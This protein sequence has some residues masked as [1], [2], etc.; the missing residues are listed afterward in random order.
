MA[1]TA[2]SSTTSTPAT[3]TTSSSSSNSTD[4]AK[5]AAAQIISSLGMG[6][7]V[8]TQALAQ[9]LADAE[10]SP[11]KALVNDKI[12]KAQ[13][14]ISGYA[15][16]KYVLGNLQSAFTALKDKSSFNSLT[17]SISQPN[18]VSITTTANATA[19]NH[20][21]VVNS[22][23]TADKKLSNGFA[24]GSV[25][26]NGGSAMSLSLSVHGATAATISVPA[27]FDTPGG[28]VGY[29]N[30][31]NL[32]V[33]AQLVNTGNAT[34]PYQIMVSG[35]TGANNNFTLT[36]N[37]TTPV[38]FNTSL[39]T[40][41]NGNVNV[42]GMALTP[43]TNTMTDLIPGTTLTFS[44]PTTGSGAAVGL[45]RDTSTVTANMQALVTAYNDA[46]TMLNTVSD[47]KSTVTTYGATLV[48]N[49]LVNTVRNTIRSMFLPSGIM[50]N[51]NGVPNSLRDLGV[52]IDKTG[53]M[54][55]DNTKLNSVLATNYDDV[56]K[57]MTNNLEGVSTF[58][59]AA[60][61]IAGDAVRNLS[62]MVSDTS[63]LGTQSANQT[64]NIA[65]YQ[66]QLTTLDTRMTQ[67]LA[68][69]NTQLS[70]MD[71][72]VGQ[73]KSLQASLTNTFAGMSAM[74]TNK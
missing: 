44:A 13:N 25:A 57:L 19:G 49:S 15:A 37:S 43:A 53:T 24:S 23:A 61:G 5:T 48:G 72:M 52:S 54:T 38:N 65:T 6:S 67:I 2:V 60:S 41:A 68:R 35:T 32:G 47:P 22:L 63:S 10:I 9:S 42:D 30:Q 33:T 62:N 11:Q 26:L 59:T 21:V 20:T 39:Q 18:S 56:T 4:S 45:S 28:V 51:A 3:T 58:Y 14:R 55:L 29:I 31:A 50:P 71:T 7:G 1:T 34:N 70:A 73:T 16:I 17:S 36:S 27:G 66:T 8:N 46:N 69:Y 40:A 12:T 64:T 74:Y